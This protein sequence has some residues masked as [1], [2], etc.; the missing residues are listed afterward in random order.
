MEHD[1]AN[2]HWHR[3]SSHRTSEGTVHYDSCPCGAHRV[4]LAQTQIAKAGPASPDAAPQ[5]G[6]QPI[7]DAQPVR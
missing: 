2:H 7:P 5:A 3:R 1:T 6:E 4:R